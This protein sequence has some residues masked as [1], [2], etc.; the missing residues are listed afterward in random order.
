MITPIFDMRSGATIYRP[1]RT[2]SVAAPPI[3]RRPIPS[4]LSEQPSPLM[5]PGSGGGSPDAPMAGGSS[6]AMSGLV[7]LGVIGFGA[8]IVSRVK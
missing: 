8:W 6:P 3:I 1:D 2:L 5:A 4:A 7:L